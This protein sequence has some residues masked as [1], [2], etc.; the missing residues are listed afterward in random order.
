[1]RRRNPRQS[2]NVFFALFAAT[3]MVGLVGAALNSV[4]RGPATT[5]AN[6]TRHTSAE[7]HMIMASRLAV[8]GAVTQ[9]NNGDCDDDAFV[10][11]LPWRDAG[12]VPHPNGGGLLPSSIGA[13]LTDP[14]G[15][16]YGYCAF[17]HGPKSVSDAVP[18][19][20]TPPRRLQGSP[21]EDQPV[22]AIVS[23]GKDRLFQTTC[24]AYVDA[25]APLGEP[26]TKLVDKP[27]GSDDIV[28]IFTYAEASK[29]SDGLWKL[30]DSDID[31]AEIGKNVE[32]QGSAS[33]E[34]AL[35]L[36]GG[37]IL[38]DQTTSG[39]CDEANQDQIR[40]N[41][42]VPG[43]T[44][45]EICNWDSV[46]S[47]GSWDKISG[48]GGV[49]AGAVVAFSGPICPSGW[50]PVTNLAGRV[51]IGAGTLGVDTYTS[52]ISTGGA[53]RINLSAAQMPAHNHSIAGATATGTAAN[54]GSAHTH[55]GSVTG[56]G[57][58]NHNISGTASGGSHNHTYKFRGNT[59]SDGGTGNTHSVVWKSTTTD[60]TT[61]SGDHF[62]GV[63]G[64]TTTLGDHSHGL[65]INSTGAHT[66]PVSV[67][68]AAGTLT[69]SIGSGDA[70]DIRMPYRA[71]VYCESDG[72]PV[73]G[74]TL[75]NCSSGETLNWNGTAWV[76]ETAGAGLWQLHAN[77]TDIY[78]ASGNVGIGTPAPG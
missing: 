57:A 51:I 18:A 7:N 77:N 26:D 48:A 31:T 28:T 30:K 50:N 56:V 59:F 24:T 29:Y 23:A 78:R 60:T 27:N 66:H 74:V 25:V 33:I 6:V 41:T 58:H 20:G 45:L 17:D 21:N 53:P 44:A 15:S 61:G 35:T 73:E 70:V 3:A 42:S 40:R 52:N 37:L 39:D 1:M 54:T 8:A 34:G 19:C 22:I 10:E 11:P 71:Y 14:W 12:A 46:S 63:S 36:G 64:S 32:V 47:T 65:T 9:D 4:V 16:Q 67:T 38:P 76:C 69:G 43:T 13:S 75:P 62:H 55:T 72:T 49:P 5:A 2:G 68:V